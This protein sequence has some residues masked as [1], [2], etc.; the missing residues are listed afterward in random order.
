MVDGQEQTR[1]LDDP[2]LFP[3]R[4]DPAAR[5]LLHR[6]EVDEERDCFDAEHTGYVRLPQPVVHRRQIWFDKHNGLW[7]VRDLL[8]GVGEHRAIGFLHLAPLQ[9]TITSQN[10][11]VVTVG[12]HARSLVIAWLPTPALSVSVTDGWISPRYGVK[13][14][15]P[16][17]CYE[18]S[19]SFPMQVAF[20]MMPRRRGES[21]EVAAALRWAAEL[22]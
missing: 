18:M 1:L 15:A 9:V 19:G 20:V 17:V 13:Q 12:D 2:T 8:T 6:W 21:L 16:V 7:A 4:S 22:Q 5:F 10:P 14:K 3:I 11:W